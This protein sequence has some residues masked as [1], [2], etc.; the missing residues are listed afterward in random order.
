MAYV[1]FVR[2]KTQFDNLG[3]ALINRELLR[4]CSS[5]GTV[6]VRC[7]G[8]PDDFIKWLDLKSIPNIYVV[9]GGGEYGL[10]FVRDL[11]CG[12]IRRRSM[13]LVLNPGGYIG[14]ISKKSLFFR[15]FRAAYLRF[16]SALGVRSVLL[17]ASYES[18]GRNNL[19]SIRGIADSLTFHIVRDLGTRDYCLEKKIRVSKVLPDLAFNL[20]D[21]GVERLRSSRRVCL[22]S[23]RDPKDVDV[24]ECI[25]QQ[26]AKAYANGAFSAVRLSFQVRRDEKIMVDLQSRLKSLCI[27]IDGGLGMQEEGVGAAIDD[28]ADAAYVF[29]NR[30]HV[31][32]LAWRGGVVPMPFLKTGDNRKIEGIFADVGLADLC[33]REASG[34]D[35]LS[36]VIQRV[37]TVVSPKELRERFN[38]LGSSLRNGF[39]DLLRL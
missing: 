25:V 19:A 5:V 9:R 26:V 22:L 28:Y 36:S 31:L 29:S 6:V 17:G 34:S 23:F 12:A 1:F 20:P 10:L 3:D 16:L 37:E 30:L 7:D 15:R 14:E 39:S 13:C 35:G 11:I 8:A 27:P 38:S 18:L 21:P 33:V 2:I 4:L 32:L 24:L